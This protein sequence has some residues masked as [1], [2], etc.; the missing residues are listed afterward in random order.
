[1]EKEIGGKAMY[2]SPHKVTTFCCSPVKKNNNMKMKMAWIMQTS[3][4][5]MVLSVALHL[6]LTKGCIGVYSIRKTGN[7]WVIST[8][9]HYCG[10]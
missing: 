9:Y 1:M 5:L 8:M 7:K 10:T 2:F 3:M 6:K 4:L